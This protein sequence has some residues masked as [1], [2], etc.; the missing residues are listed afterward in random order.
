METPLAQLSHIKSQSIAL[1]M[2][3][4]SCLASLTYKYKGFILGEVTAELHIHNSWS[5]RN[6][7]HL[8][9]GSMHK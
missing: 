1:T 3:D 4:L 2:Q 8:S 7:L 9:T 6:C 5:P